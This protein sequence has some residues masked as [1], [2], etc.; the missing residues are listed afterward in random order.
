LVSNP[1][2]HGEALV[3]TPAGEGPPAAPAPDRRLGANVVV[4]A[5]DPTLLELLKHSLDGR[6][7]VWRAENAMHAGDLLVAAQSGILLI[8]AGA[9]RDDTP[10]LVDSLHNQFPDMPIVVIG[11]RDDELRLGERIST[12]VVF[13][14]LHK[15]ASAERVRNFV[16][17]AA[18]R[19]E[20]APPPPRARPEFAPLAAARSIR[21]PRIVVD[22]AAVMRRLRGA[23]PVLL[24]LLAASAIVALLQQ[25]P[26]QGRSASDSPVPVDA[27]ASSPAPVVAQPLPQDARLLSAAGVALSQG[28]LASPPGANAIELYRAVL[29]REPDNAEARRGLARTAEALLLAVEQDIEAGN[30][31]AAASA[32]DAARSADPTNE[33]LDFYSSL[34]DRERQRPQDVVPPPADIDAAAER[35]TA[36]HVD[37]LLALADARMRQGRLAGGD[38]AETYVLEA[39]AASPGDAGVQQAVSALSARMLLEA[40][41]AARDGDWRTAGRWLER[42]DTLGVDTAAVARL[43]AEL[44]SSRVASVQEDRSRLLALANQ[45]IAQGRL[46]EPRGDSARHYVDLLRSGDPD[47]PG[48]E[49]TEALLASRLQ[50]TGTTRPA[51]PP[52]TTA[53]AVTTPAVLPETD[54]TRISHVPP[55]YPPRARARATEGWVE[56]QFTVAADGTTRDAVILGSSPAQV[57]DQAVLDAVSK[58]TYRPRLVGGTPVDQRVQLRVRF[59]LSG[60]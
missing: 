45:R 6:Q 54:L 50:E 4:L 19:L 18:R 52:A 35:A 34:L 31:G 46:T 30:M 27:Q 57:F 36:E 43:R 47:Y 53:K 2:T 28:R 13:R 16:D 55:A 33:R 1:I 51:P 48:L 58:W 40:S 7:R 38:S 15:P 56:V 26:R 24:A 14:F 41:Q 12:G 8:D 20:E 59:R 22:R 3:E 11:R 42:A 60:G 29:L 23:M 39:R 21:L 44:E 17:A 9:N 10:A 49:E 25:M 37:R 32:L 5:S